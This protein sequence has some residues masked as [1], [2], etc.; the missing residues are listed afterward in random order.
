MGLLSGMCYREIRVLGNARL[1]LVVARSCAC[2]WGYFRG[3]RRWGKTAVSQTFANGNVPMLLRN[4]SSVCGALIPK[5]RETATSAG[6]VPAVLPTFDMPRMSPLLR[7]PHLLGPPAGLPI[8]LET[9]TSAGSVQAVS[10]TFAKGNVLMPLRNL[11]SVCDVLKPKGRETAVFQTFSIRGRPPLLRWSHLSGKPVGFPITLETAVSQTF[12]KGNVPMLLRHLSSVC[13]VLK[14]NGRETAVLPTFDMPGISPLLCWSHL[15]GQPVGLPITLETAVSAGSVQA[16]SQTF[17][18]GNVPMP[19]CTLSSVCDTLIPKGRETAISRPFGIRDRPVLLRWSHLL[20]KPAGLP[21]AL[22]TAVS[23][24]S[25]QAVLPS[26]DARTISLTKTQRHVRV[27]ETMIK[28]QPSLALAMLRSGQAA[29]G[30]LWLLL[31]YLD[32]NGRGWLELADIRARLTKKGSPT[33][34]CGQ[35]QLRALLQQGNGIFWQRDKTRVWLSSTAKVAAGLG[36]RRLSGNPIALPLAVLLE[37]IGL[38]RAHLYASFHSSRMGRSGQSAAPIS[39]VSL[40]AVSGV[41]RRSQHAYERRA[42]V[43][44]RPNIALGAPLNR[45]ATETVAWHHGRAAFVFTD[46]QGKQGKPGQ[47]Y[48][49]WRLPNSYSGP[50]T[51]LGRGRQRQLNRQLVDLRHN[52]DAGNG[53]LAERWRR[54]RYTANGVLA[55]RCQK[56]APQAWVYWLGRDGRDAAFWYVL[57]SGVGVGA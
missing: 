48:L 33:R 36:V 37:P 34:L 22:E 2:Y 43:V 24:V 46:R 44:V 56:Q 39:R 1:W 5:G 15:L 47:Q 40:T 20:D 53:R 10:Q 21:I 57:S 8:A 14:P 41:S 19:L 42:G 9:A 45:H 6:S 29:T 26:P 17:A 51:R 30:R 18:N 31:R 25:A 7:W 52:G 54:R 28:L 35:R 55:A 27:E 11:S 49:A 4:L 38:V 50:H 32:E 3:E 12:A 23:A 16:V 13:D